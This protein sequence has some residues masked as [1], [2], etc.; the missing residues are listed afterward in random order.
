MA[1]RKSSPGLVKGTLD[2][3][4][5]KALSGESRHGY[6]IA[7]WLERN[8]AG[9]LGVEDSAIY[10]AL[11]RLQGRRLVEAE[12]GTSENNRRARYYKLTRTGRRQLASEATTWREYAD[13]VTA[14]LALDESA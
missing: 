13:S 14:I 8:S 3:L 6:G 4:V 1:A 10:Q 11:H 9:R 2:L 7:A 12:W 5:L